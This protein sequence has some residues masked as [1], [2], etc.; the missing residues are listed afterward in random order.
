MRTRLRILTAT[1]LVA[2]FIVG[3]AGVATAATTDASVRS[4]TNAPS[5]TKVIDAWSARLSLLQTEWI[6][7]LVCPAD[8]PYLVDQDLSPG[9]FVPRGVEVIESESG[10]GVTIPRTSVTDASFSARGAGADG[11]S[12]TNW[13]TTSKVLIRLHCTSDRAAS[14]WVTPDNREWGNQGH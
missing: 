12:A 7:Q 10:I 9:R 8:A 1:G 4:T 13:G 3:S 6:P 11:A 14:Y 5:T 2:A